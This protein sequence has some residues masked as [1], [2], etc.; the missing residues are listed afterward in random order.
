MKEN[1]SRN[2]VCIPAQKRQFP[3]YTLKLP[4]HLLTCIEKAHFRYMFKLPGLLTCNEKAH[5]R[6][7][8]NRDDHLHMYRKSPFSIHVWAAQHVS[9]RPMFDTRMGRSTCIEKA[10]VRYMLSTPPPNMYRKSQFSIHVC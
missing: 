6:Y 4:G 10:H 1:L 9:K 3:A 7:M 5:F 8:C 2:G